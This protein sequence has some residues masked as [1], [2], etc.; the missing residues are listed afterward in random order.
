MNNKNIMKNWL[1]NEF[2]FDIPKDVINIIEGELKNEIDTHQV[3]L[4][5]HRLSEMPWYTQEQM[6][7]ELGIE[8]EN[9]IMLNE[10][11]RHNDYFQDLIVTEDCYQKISGMSIQ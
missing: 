1:Q 8:K 11:I 6:M 9:L 4:I 7:N 5:I 10:I 3:A 2:E